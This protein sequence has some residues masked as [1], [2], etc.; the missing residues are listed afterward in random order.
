MPHPGIIVVAGLWVAAWALILMCQS[1]WVP[2]CKSIPHYWHPITVDSRW[3]SP[4][5]D[6]TEWASAQH[7]SPEGSSSNGYFEDVVCAQ[8]C[9]KWYKCR[10]ENL[11]GMGSPRVP[12]SAKT[13]LFMN[14]VH[15]EPTSR[16]LPTGSHTGWMGL[17][18]VATGISVCEPST[19]LG[20]RTW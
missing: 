9:A 15:A 12:C 6:H 13:C 8:H 10:N 20:I 14:G 7:W 18:T 17:N 2:L 4:G 5:P 3:R 16:S 19:L 11:K 1:L